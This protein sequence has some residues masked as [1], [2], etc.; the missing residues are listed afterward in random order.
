MGTTERLVVWLRAAVKERVNAERK[1]AGED[2]KA[3]VYASHARPEW[4]PEGWDWSSRALEAAN[5]LQ[6]EAFFLPMRDWKAS[7]QERE[8]RAAVARKRGQHRPARGEDTAGGQSEDA[9]AAEVSECLPAA[10]RESGSSAMLTA[11]EAAGS[12]EA[13]RQQLRPAS[14]LKRAYAVGS[15]T[16]LQSA[17]LRKNEKLE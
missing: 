15:D 6:L 3:H 4:W 17:R 8:V 11:S 12:G 2:G 14:R 16:C 1:A 9:S 13:E 7:H 10:D 5:R